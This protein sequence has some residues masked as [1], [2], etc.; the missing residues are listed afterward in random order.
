MA[1]LLSFLTDSCKGFL[2]FMLRIFYEGF[3]GV[4]LSFISDIP[5][6]LNI[7]FFRDF[8]GGGGLFS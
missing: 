2:T 8:V 1:H 6:L 4:D 3:L 5:F 7:E